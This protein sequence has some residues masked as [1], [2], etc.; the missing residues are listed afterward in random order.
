MLFKQWN[1]FTEPRHH[2]D[3]PIDERDELDSL[4]IEPFPQVSLAKSID[5]SDFKR[6]IIVGKTLEPLFPRNL[7]ARREVSGF[8]ITWHTE[9]NESQKFREDFQSEEI[10]GSMRAEHTLELPIESFGQDSLI[11]CIH[12]NFLR[13]SPIVWNILGFEI[14]KYCSGLELLV[15]GTADTIQEIKSLGLPAYDANLPTLI[16][17]EFITSFTASI[18]TQLIVLKVPFQ[19][20]IAPSEGPSGFEKLR[21]TT[22]DQLID[23]CWPLSQTHARDDYAKACHRHWKLNGTAMGAQAGLYV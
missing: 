20:L 1:N 22:M 21:L 2:L 9:I 17:P 15:L 23:L 7:V 19:A 11:L 6:L 4:K 5:F 14:A 16:P 8:K 3:A 13:V 18:L 10:A 12:E